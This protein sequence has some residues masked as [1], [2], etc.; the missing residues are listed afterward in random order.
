KQYPNRWRPAKKTGG[1]KPPMLGEATPYDGSA[2]YIKITKLDPKLAK[3]DDALFVESHLLFIE[4]KDWFPDGRD[5]LSPRI[6]SVVQSQ[7]RS[8]RA[9]V[10]KLRP[11]R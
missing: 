3:A 4:P 10:K 6:A 8:F 9:D 7:A 11:D 2:C 5:R 1:G